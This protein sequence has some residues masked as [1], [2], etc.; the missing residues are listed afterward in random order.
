MSDLQS[1]RGCLAGVLP[2]PFIEFLL[3]VIDGSS[4]SNAARLELPKVMIDRYFVS[5]AECALMH[6]LRRVVGDRA[7][8]LAQVSLQQLLYFPQQRDDKKKSS[9]AAWQNKVRA[10]SV[11]FLLCCPKTMKPLVAIE[12]DDRTHEQEG[13]KARD[14][15]VVKLFAAAGLPLLRI[16][17]GR[18]DDVKSLQ[19]A[20]AP[21]LQ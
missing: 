2:A 12:Y 11:D 4:R 6:S 14:A 5:D 9:R 18:G 17:C 8:I 15:E 19:N 20:L 13:R 16:Q 10:K 3:R 1:Q 7:H 21:H